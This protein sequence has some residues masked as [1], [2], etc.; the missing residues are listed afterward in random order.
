MILAIASGKG[1][2]GKT[3]VSLNLAKS[4]GR[5]VQLL[6][7]DVEEPNAHLFLS[8]KPGAESVVTVP[9]PVI[10]ATRCDLCGECGRVCQFHAIA[11][12]KP[13]PIVFPELC[14]GCGG[15]VLACPQKAISEKDRR[16]GAVETLKSGDI[17]LIMGRLDVGVSLVPPLIRAVKSRLNPE[18][19]AILDAPPGTSC[20]VVATIRDTDY[21]L[22]VTE[23]TPFGLN[24]LALAVDMVRELKIPF[25]VVVNRA[26]SGDDGVNA[27]CREQ[28]IPILL[29]I[30]DDRRIA[31]AYSRGVLMVDALP[32][33]RKMFADLADTLAATN[34]KK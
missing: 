16:I 33:Y 2:T 28:G 3:T 31:E 24:D 20:P 23:P 11:V 29:E 18:I 5:P 27:Y 32:E 7:C 10:D 14:H 21:V 13:G 15:C 17:T 12:V 4:L 26:G 22:L 1:G 9:V 6:D 8:G 30:P 34:G 25:G 19:P